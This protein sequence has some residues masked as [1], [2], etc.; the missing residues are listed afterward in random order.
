MGKTGINWRHFETLALYYRCKQ[1]VSCYAFISKYGV[2]YAK[3]KKKSN[4]WRE[5][6]LSSGD[7]KLDANIFFR[8]DF[9]ITYSL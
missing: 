8:E 3:K 6:G 5:P 7:I 4:K 1:I 9:G 2:L